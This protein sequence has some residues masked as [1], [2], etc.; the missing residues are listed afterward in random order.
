[1]KFAFFALLFLA[2][3]TAFFFGLTAPLVAPTHKTYDTSAGEVAVE[4]VAGPFAHAWAVTF[5]PDGA[6]LVTERGG[7]LWRLGPD[8]VRAEF[9]PLG[10]EVEFDLTPITERQKYVRADL[11]NYVKGV[12]DAVQGI[13]IKDDRLI[14]AIYASFTDTI[15]EEQ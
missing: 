8:G 3:G 5:L 11:D 1:M 6:M 12:L 14:V 7:R 10:I 2:T 4:Q 15:L 13:V 9:V